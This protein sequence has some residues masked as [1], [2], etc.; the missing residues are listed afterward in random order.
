M[1]DGLRPSRALPLRVAPGDVHVWLAALDC[2]P[3]LLERLQSTLNDKEHARAARFKVARDRDR[4]ATAHG[5]LRVILGR[6]L[7]VRPADI[8]LDADPR[9]KPRLRLRPSD[10]PLAFS[11]SHSQ[12]LGLIAVSR[13]EIGVDIE[14]VHATVADELAERV[15]SSSEFAKWRKLPP[16][17]RA[18]AFYRAWTSKEAYVKARGDGLQF[19]LK[20]VEVLLGPGQRERLV[21]EDGRRWSLRLIRPAVG[22]VA[23]VVVESTNPRL[24]VQAWK[25]PHTGLPEPSGSVPP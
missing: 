7:E 21:C 4:Y 1:G 19:P 13:T 14:Q 24:H 15:L 6:Y 10:P 2:E 22:Y 20:E 16:A 5:T 3:A 9:G 25:D 23:A 11:L 8:V 12:G 18:D 17:E